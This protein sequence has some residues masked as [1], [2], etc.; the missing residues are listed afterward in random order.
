[1]NFKMKNFVKN[2]LSFTFLT[3]LLIACSKEEDIAQT[4]NAPDNFNA[5]QP[6]RGNGPNGGGGNGGN[7]NPNGG[8]T[9]NGNNTADCADIYTLDATRGACSESLVWSS[10][11][12]M[13]VSNG[14]RTFRS[15]GIPNHK[16]GIFGGGT[17]SLNPNAI[18]E[19]NVIVSITTNP[20]KTNSITPLLNLNTGPAYSF[21]ILLN[22]VEIDPVAAE[23]WPHIRGF[24]LN[25]SNWNWNLDAM[26]INLGLDCNN[27]HVQP[28]G[29]YHYHGAPTLF[30]QELNA[31]M[32]EMT[33][34]G[35]A[36]D[37][38]PIYHKYGYNNA[39]NANSG[40]KELA[41]SYQLKKGERP[42]DGDSAPC[43]AYS[44]IYSNDYE[45]I[46]C[47]GD[48]DEC[49]GRTGITPEYPQGTYYYVIT[50][51]FPFV[52]RC[53]VGS[54]SADFRFAR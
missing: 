11:V 44:G 10:S 49:N 5:A 22:G 13:T 28:T 54:P 43:G 46:A 20:Q 39:N 47:S 30:L 2:F 40:I 24:S 17:G 27:A 29:K 45:Y 31:P 14:I 42:G 33:L 7:T 51:Q 4:V 37:G 8:T 26:A 15:N 38:F 52:S 25:A 53:F 18:T 50:E 19:Q 41:S 48:L 34:L 12:N 21:G 35:Y 36:A 1:M 23:P 3:L 6:N 16:T 9:N 32:N